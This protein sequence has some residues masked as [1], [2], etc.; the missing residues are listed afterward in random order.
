MIEIAFLFRYNLATSLAYF[1][2]VKSKKFI[3]YFKD[4]PDEICTVS[5]CVGALSVLS[6]LSLFFLSSGISCA[7]VGDILLQG[8]LYVTHNYIGFHSNVFGYV[9]KV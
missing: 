9:T 8:H 1:V 7:L 4:L 5:E 3:K 2:L 6:D